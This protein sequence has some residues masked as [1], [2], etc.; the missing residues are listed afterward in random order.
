MSDHRFS[1][2]INRFSWLGLIF[3][4]AILSGW[5]YF[6]PPG[7]LGKA[8]AIGYAVCHRIQVRSFQFGQRQLPLCARCSGMYLGAL[9]GILYHLKAGRKGGLPPRKILAALGLLLVVFGVDGTNSYFHLFPNFTG[10]YEP[11]NI[12]RLFTGTGMGVGMA[13]LL[14]PIMHQ[15]FWQVWDP[16]PALKQWHDLFF[17]LA[18]ALAVS[19]LLLTENPLLLYPLALLSAATVIVILGLIYTILWI[20][21]FKKENI[22]NRLSEIYGFLT[23]GFGTAIMQIFLFDIARLI[24]TG[25]WNGF[26]F[27]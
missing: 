14:M 4:T 3:L 12:I 8:D 24:L 7:L 18:A 26:N 13:A 9:V 16:E 5:L 25:T 2:R 1:F 21:I 23:F 6:A 10:L 11:N 19:S 15:T 20:T 22:F 27:S 17:L